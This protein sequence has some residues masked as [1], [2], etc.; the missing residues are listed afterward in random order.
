[1]PVQALGYL[2]LGAS[3]LDDRTSFAT[4]QLGPQ[5]AAKRHVLVVGHCGWRFLTGPGG[6]KPR[7]VSGESC[8]RSNR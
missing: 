3:Q 2:G 5:L 4:A 8:T 7:H 6:T 1:M